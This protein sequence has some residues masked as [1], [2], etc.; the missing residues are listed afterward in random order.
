MTPQK[1]RRS[2]ITVHDDAMDHPKIEALSD[3]AKVHWIRLTG[4]SNRHRSDGIVSAQK[5]KEKGAKVFRELTTE[6]VPNCGSILELQPDG[7]YYIHDYLEHQ[8]SKA[9]IE[10][11]AADKQDSGHYG[12]HIRW[13]ENRNLVELDCQYCP[14][15]T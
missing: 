4:W 12:L 10:K 7:R 13:H 14:N 5:A 15:S 8:W 1:D 9:E 11:R 2:Y 6:L 3:A